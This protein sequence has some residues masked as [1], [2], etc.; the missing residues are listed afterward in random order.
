MQTVTYFLIN[1]MSETSKKDLPPLKGITRIISNCPY[2]CYNSDFMTNPLEN[3]K[4]LGL[5]T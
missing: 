5:G 4:F 2:K 1:E 3:A